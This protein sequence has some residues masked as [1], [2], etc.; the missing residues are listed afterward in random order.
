M[1]IA[2][3]LA[4]LIL[5]GTGA[6]TGAPAHPA[7]GS[8]SIIPVSPS[9][10]TTTPYDQPNI[11]AEFSDASGTVELASVYL[12]LDGINVTQIQGF[13]VTSKA[14]YY[15]PVGIL[16]LKDGDHNVTVGAIDSAGNKAV[17]SWSFMV[18]TSLAIAAPPLQGISVKA[19]VIDL[20]IGGAIFTAGFFGYILYL[21]QTRKFR[22]RKYFATHPLQ[23]EYLSLYIPAIFAILF[24]L[25]TLVWVYSTPGLPLGAPEYVVVVAAFIGLTTYALDSRAQIQRMRTS[26]RAF[27]QFLFEMADA[28]RGGIDPAKAIV[29][30]STTSTNILRKPL[31]IASDGIRMGRPIDQVLRSLAEPLRSPLITRYAELIADAATVGGETATVVHRAAKDMDDFIK[32]EFE[33]SQALTLPVAVLYIS[34]AV[35]LAVLF[36]LLSIAPSL[37]AINFSIVTGTNPL[38][39]GAAASTGAA[40]KLTGST[41]ELRFLDL[42]LINALGTGVI[43]GAFTEGKPKYGLVHSLALLGATSFAFLFLAP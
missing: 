43:I 19:I 21:R 4:A 2:L 36:S 22:F 25:V 13:F 30:L 42:S 31:R 16:K 32:I 10:N 1:R 7:T 40:Q 6:V 29:E 33:R 34:F 3:F 20:I 14:V 39:G 27:A 41:L 37:G 17:V 8:I 24:L 28:M 38:G 11:T 15:Q 35:L 26:E 23:R 18:N 9:N 5:L 12:D